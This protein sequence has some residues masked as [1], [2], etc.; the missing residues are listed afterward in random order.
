MW[1][2]SLAAVIGGC[3]LSISLMLNIRFLLPLEIESQLFIGLVLAFPLWVAVMVACYASRHAKQAWTRCLI[4]L[5]PSALIN[6]F[7]LL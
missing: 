1:T 4:L 7:F 2:K 3:I 5:V 6:T